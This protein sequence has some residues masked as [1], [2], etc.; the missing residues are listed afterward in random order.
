MKRQTMDCGKIFTDH[1]SDNGQWSIIYK[2]L[3]KFNSIK[4]SNLI[5]KQVEDVKRCFTEEDIQMVEKHCKDVNTFSYQAD[6]N[7]D[8]DELFS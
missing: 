6:A 7:E 4:I 8:Y 3:S 2:K 5:R 1:M